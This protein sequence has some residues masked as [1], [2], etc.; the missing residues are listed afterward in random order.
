M[1]N[2]RSAKNYYSFGYLEEEEEN[3]DEDAYY[4]LNKFNE[5]KSDKLKRHYEDIESEEQDV[6]PCDRD[7]DEINRWQPNIKPNAYLVMIDKTNYF[8]I[9]LLPLL[10]NI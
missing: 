9:L 4:N 2:N 1:S 8:L 6:E 5:N 10:Y 7:D 3:D